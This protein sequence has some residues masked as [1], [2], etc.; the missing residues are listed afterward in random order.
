MTIYPAVEGFSPPLG[1]TAAISVFPNREVV[2]AQRVVDAAVAEI[3]GYL[4]NIADP[5]IASAIRSEAYGMQ[6]QVRSGQIDLSAIAGLKNAILALREEARAIASGEVTGRA[7]AAQRNYLDTLELSAASQL[8][9]S[10]ALH[11]IEANDMASFVSIQNEFLNP[12]FRDSATA[13]T[14]DWFMNHPEG[15]QTWR[16]IQNA[17]PEDRQAALETLER[18]FQ[19][20]NERIAQSTGEEKAMYER[21][22][23]RGATNSQHFDD[24]VNAVE[25]GQSPEI[26]ASKVENIERDRSARDTVNLSNA[27][28]S[29]RDNPLGRQADRLIN[30]S[31]ANGINIADDADS[32]MARVQYLTGEENLTN[33]RSVEREL[34]LGRTIENLSPELLET[35]TAMSLQASLSAQA[36]AQAFG[37]EITRIQLLKRA[38]NAGHT[39]D[40][41]SVK[42]IRNFEFIN[43]AQQP[44]TQRVS[45][46]M[47]TV[48]T[49]LEGSAKMSPDAQRGLATLT[50]LYADKAG[51]LENHFSM[52]NGAGEAAE[53]YRRDFNRFSREI[54]LGNSNSS[55]AQR[56]GLMRLDLD[57]ATELLGRRIGDGSLS[58]LVNSDETL[59]FRDNNTGKYSNS[60]VENRQTLRQQAYGTNALLQDLFKETRS[61]DSTQDPFTSIVRRIDIY[62][63]SEDP[64]AQSILS[65]ALQD[66]SR[67]SALNNQ[68]S[69]LIQ[70]AQTRFSEI[71]PTV[72]NRLPENFLA[73]LAQSGVL[74]DGQLNIERA[75]QL[76]EINKVRV[77]DYWENYTPFTLTQ[78]QNLERLSANPQNEE[79]VR[80]A[81][82]QV[83]DAMPETTEA[84]RA[85]KNR[86]SSLLNLSVQEIHAQIGPDAS[87]G[88]T[89]LSDSRI[90]AETT[91][92]IRTTAAIDSLI[93]RSAQLE[94]DAARLTASGQAIPARMQEDLEL[95]RRLN[96]LSPQSSSDDVTAAQTAITTFS[97]RDSY[98][99]RKEEGDQGKSE[100]DQSHLVRSIT[101]TLVEAR[102]GSATQTEI[103]PTVPAA[104]TPL[105]ASSAIIR[106]SRENEGRNGIGD[107][108]TSN[109]VERAVQAVVN[110]MPAELRVANFGADMGTKNVGDT[111]FI[112]YHEIENRLKELGYNTVAA[113]DKDGNGVDVNDIRTALRTPL[114]A[115]QETTRTP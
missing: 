88:S 37:E 51:G 102:M 109:E 27:M 62:N 86:V 107:W 100:A 114:V 1:G 47:E 84:E 58:I 93:G 28:T 113:I 69:A 112:S 5:A 95:V 39:L 36:K 101:N 83:R 29:S 90:L 63:L 57:R 85:A 65:Q 105:P 98:I 106:D 13:A 89:S 21:L 64:Q 14:T 111:N 60:L 44:L 48:G 43:D 99:R 70:D 73:S 77:L 6:A 31:R 91:T 49:R 53:A 30:A 108:L 94:A 103:A 71:A 4:R 2:E 55:S 67:A 52:M 45:R 40:E 74:V 66:R 35:A 41:T 115:G 92:I 79:M 38:Q 80:A 24:F 16:I 11:A 50:L 78:L 3:E 32:I 76:R 9:V 25:S 33:I 26:I 54:L 20:L 72:V 8:R 59:Q 15:Q 110:T 7:S 68:L 17:T 10:R 12:A 87:R 75:M 42:A 22:L 18:R 19:W 104:D 81:I 97:M 46:L 56:D 96:A 23:L 34:A 61:N 82:T